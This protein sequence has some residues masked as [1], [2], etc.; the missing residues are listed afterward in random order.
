MPIQVRFTEKALS[1]VAAAAVSYDLNRQ[2]AVRLAAAIGLRSL[3]RMGWEGMT[4]AVSAKHPIRDASAVRG[5]RPG[6]EER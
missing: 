6:E 4:D 2:E 5:S 1:D 3:R